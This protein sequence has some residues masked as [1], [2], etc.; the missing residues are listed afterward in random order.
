VKE[1]DKT[2][3]SMKI[4][5]TSYKIIMMVMDL[6]IVLLFKLWIKQNIDYSKRLILI[7]N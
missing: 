2:V 4:F 6:E 1:K 7:N 3:T 5:F